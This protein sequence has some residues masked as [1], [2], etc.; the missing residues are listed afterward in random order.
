MTTDKYMS[1]LYHHGILGMKWGVRRYQNKDGSLTAAGRKRAG[2]SSSER[3]KTESSFKSFLDKRKTSKAK[4]DAKK[5]KKEEETLEK[6]KERILK[7]RSAAE[8]YKNADLFTTE[9]LQS[10]YIRLQLEKNISQLIPAKV[11]KGRE[12]VEN[13]AKWGNTVNSLAKEGIGLYNNVAKVYNAFS[14]EAKEKP[15]V[16][17][18]SNEKK[19]D[20]GKDND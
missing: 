19:K 5:E 7:S 10:A 20:K 15:M 11:K 3:E 6:K 12:Q 4:R 13:M 17:I 14:E 1:E 2:Y 9:E 16:I 8:L 18:G